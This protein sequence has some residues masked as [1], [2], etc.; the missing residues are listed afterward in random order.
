MEEW[1]GK[2][3]AYNLFGT[4][5]RGPGFRSGGSLWCKINRI[6]QG[7]G[8]SESRCS[9][10]E[11]AAAAAAAAASKHAN[12]RSEPLLG[13]EMGWREILVLSNKDTNYSAVLPYLPTLPARRWR[14]E[15]GR[16]R[17]RL[18]STPVGVRVRHVIE[19]PTRNRERLNKRE[20][21]GRVGIRS[22]ASAMA[23]LLF[24]MCRDF[25][26]LDQKRAV[27]YGL[28]LRATTTG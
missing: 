13:R 8:E 3:R 1:Q 4:G 10:W 14:W 19:A 24:S 15:K 20:K 23:G 16:A 2:N 21:K 26:S 22:S 7:V 9:T 11:R 28:R 6:N 5:A 27:D 18:L 17:G 25:G 12:T